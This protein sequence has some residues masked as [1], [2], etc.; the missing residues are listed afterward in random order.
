MLVRLLATAEQVCILFGQNQVLQVRHDRGW[1]L[2]AY[3]YSCVLGLGDPHRLTFLQCRK[4]TNSQTPP[5]QG[6]NQA[7]HKLAIGAL[8]AITLPFLLTLKTY[9]KQF[10]C[11]MRTSQ[12]PFIY[13]ICCIFHMYSFWITQSC[14]CPS[15]KTYVLHFMCS[16]FDCQT[17]FNIF[18]SPY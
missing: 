16:I 10:V 17:R 1:R 7:I 6:L 12:L 14:N 4:I 11:W 15:Y 8:F 9:F 2:A 13:N 18:N 3:E 5:E